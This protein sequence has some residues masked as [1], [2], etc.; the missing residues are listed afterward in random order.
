MVH[1]F[2][3]RA[4]ARTCA[5]LQ[6]VGYWFPMRCIHEIADLVTKRY[7]IYHSGAS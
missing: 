5:A 4:C 3:S 7:F 6:A 2:D 1:E